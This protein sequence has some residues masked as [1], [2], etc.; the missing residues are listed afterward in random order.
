[1]PAPSILQFVVHGSL[2][3]YIFYPG[4]NMNAIPAT[5]VEAASN[6]NHQVCHQGG[7]MR[8]DTIASFSDG[9]PAKSIAFT[10]KV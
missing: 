6:L 3:P 9:F 8:K 10:L 4:L 7:K 5:I 2:L 1:M